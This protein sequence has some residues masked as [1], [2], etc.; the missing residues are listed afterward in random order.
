MK[1]SVLLL[2][3]TSALAAAGAAACLAVPLL[4]QLSLGFTLHSINKGAVAVIGG[5]D[6]PTAIFIT[7]GLDLA[8]LPWLGGLL[9]A[10]A[11]L[12]AVGAKLLVDNGILIARE[13]GVPESVIALT[14]IALGTSL[15]ELVTAVTSLVKGHGSLSLGNVVGANLFNLVLVCGA[16]ITLAPFQIPQSAVLF[17]RNAALVLE[18]PVMLLVM[19][20]LTVPALKKG[21]L[22][23]GQGVLMLLAYG[24][25][26]AVQFTL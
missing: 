4:L 10:G 14:F 17:G 22:Y 19:L 21:R 20:L 26:C 24:A 1:K 12:I 8:A 2:K 7:G 6:G 18:L 5:A 16:S 11:V 25:F 9:A 3:T 23:R 13:L 15:P